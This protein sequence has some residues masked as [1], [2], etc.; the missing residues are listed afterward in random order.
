M[1]NRCIITDECRTVGIY[2]HDWGAEENIDALLRYAQLQFLK[3]PQ[4]GRWNPSGL[5]YLTGIITA[6]AGRN[7]VKLLTHGFRNPGDAGIYIIGDGWEKVAHEMDSDETDAYSI[8][9][10]FIRQEVSEVLERI[11]RA[12]P[13]RM[14]LGE[15]I[16]AKKVDTIR[17]RKG[18]KVLLEGMDGPRIATVIGK[19]ME[20]YEWCMMDTKPWPFTDLT[21]Q[22]LGWDEKKMATEAKDNIN[23]YIKDRTSW[24]IPS[25]KKTAKETQ[26]TR[27]D[28]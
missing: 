20:I 7:E 9:K 5:A 4:L 10:R 22:G 21:Y 27:Q 23:A 25:E 17:L 13:V 19:G 18:Q 24:L 26:C 3:P 2:L 6:W 8:Q 14:Q 1:G 15:A 12:Q 28:A 16:H 11:D